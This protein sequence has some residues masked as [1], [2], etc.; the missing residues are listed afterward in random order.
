[1]PVHLFEGRESA[2]FFIYD[3]HITEIEKISFDFVDRGRETGRQRAIS[4]TVIEYIRSL[5][6]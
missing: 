4:P 1:M 2:L 3:N 6:G 5:W